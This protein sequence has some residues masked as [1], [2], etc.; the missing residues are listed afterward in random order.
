MQDN[1][2]WNNNK[3]DGNQAESI[4]QFLLTSIGWR[5][6][7]YGVENNISYLKENLRKNTSNLSLQIRS[8]PDFIAINEKTDTVM[9]IEAKYKGWIDRRDPEKLI[10][11]FKSK[12]INRYRK[13]WR[14]TKIIVVNN[15]NPY[16]LVINVGHIRNEHMIEEGCTL[17][18]EAAAKG[19]YYEQWNFKDIAVD[20]KE[21]FPEL[22]ED[23]LNKAIA[24]IPKK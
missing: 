5:C 13:Y 16:F 3:L 7:N 17:N 9:L 21:V 8:M 6:I 18:E 2:E 12:Q 20:I 14:E 4:V 1:S 10:F 19:N 15:Y 23:I 24:K 22:T 11:N